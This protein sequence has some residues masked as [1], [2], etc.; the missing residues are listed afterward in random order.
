[1]LPTVPKQS[2]TRKLR[3]KHLI[4]TYVHVVLFEIVAWMDKNLDIA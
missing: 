4:S 3:F 2:V 1:M